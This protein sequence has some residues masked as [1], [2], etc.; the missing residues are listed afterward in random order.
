M[1]DPNQTSVKFKEAQE[2]DQ[3]EIEDAKLLKDYYIQMFLD[4]KRDS[5]TELIQKWTHKLSQD[6]LFLYTLSQQC[7]HER[8]TMA[9]KVIYSW[10]KYQEFVND[11]FKE[12]KEAQKIDI[13]EERTLDKPEANHS[14]KIFYLKEGPFINQKYEN[15]Y[16]K[17]I[18]KE[19]EWERKVEEDKNIDFTYIYQ[20]KRGVVYE[21]KK[22]IKEEEPEQEVNQF[23]E[24][25]SEEQ[26]EEDE[27]DKEEGKD[28]Q[29]KGKSSRKVVVSQRTKR[30]PATKFR[31]LEH[32]WIILLTD[33]CNSL[34]PVRDAS[35][36][37]RIMKSCLPHL[38]LKSMNTEDIVC[39][40]DKILE[41]KQTYSS[42]I[43]L[44]DFLLLC[45][46]F[47][48][49]QRY[50]VIHNFDQSLKFLRNISSIFN[51][52]QL[53]QSIINILLQFSHSFKQL[54]MPKMVAR[55]VKEIQRILKNKG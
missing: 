7:L 17:E 28:L 50:M 21:K 40:F 47:T 23:Y 22:D 26:E 19:E 48:A 30:D 52:L 20:G 31:I 13:E 43:Y 35:V 15:D 25:E 49:L 18:M 33:L 3:L 38:Q 42:E 16:F 11:L 14:I 36:F 2:E 45:D 51:Y 8:K 32:N 12:N 29:K 34:D 5:L 24:E 1:I 9:T 4:L 44:N 54:K 27:E 41:G 10:S 53:N 55:T 6:F 37:E 46:L 39:S